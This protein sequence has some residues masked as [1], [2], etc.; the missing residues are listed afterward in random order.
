MD[1]RGPS[2]KSRPPVSKPAGPSCVICFKTQTILSVGACDHPVCFECST[3]MRVLCD[4][5]ECPICRRI[6]TKVFY[7]KLFLQ[8]VVVPF[9]Y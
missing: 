9:K 5:K 4:Q 1:R 2:F 8:F 3:T 7:F 6:M